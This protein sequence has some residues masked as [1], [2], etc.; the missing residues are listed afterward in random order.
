MEIR[1]N[2]PNSANRK[3]FN[4]SWKGWICKDCLERGKNG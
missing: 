1:E 3:R 2:K 4:L